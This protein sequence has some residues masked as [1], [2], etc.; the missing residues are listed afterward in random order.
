MKIRTDFVSN[1]SSSS[2]V[3][4]GTSFSNEQ[5]KSI[6]SNANKK[7][8]SNE[9]DEDTDYEPCEDAYELFDDAGLGV[10]SDCEAET[11]YVG[12]SPS[13][14]KDNETLKQ[15][16]ESIADKINKVAK[17]TDIKASDMEFFKGVE[18]DGYI[19]WE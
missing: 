7:N 17:V 10:V 13:E 12:L 2:F 1:S 8:D 19:D 16:K 4:F 14:M 11:I 9:E 18:C 3:L 5:L 15:F 6:L